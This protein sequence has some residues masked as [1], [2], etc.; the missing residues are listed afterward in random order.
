MHSDGE[1]TPK[2]DKQA[3]Y[4]YTKSAEQGDASAQL[5]LGIMQFQFKEIL[6]AYAW[7]NVSAAQGAEGATESRGI[8]EKIMTPSQIAKAQELS[9]EY[10]AKYVE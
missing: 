7:I 3:I 1:G 5:N 8:I 4:W 10:Y 9:K 2:N 6:I